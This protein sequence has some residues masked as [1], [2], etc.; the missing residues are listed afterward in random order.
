[1]HPFSRLSLTCCDQWLTLCLQ[2]Y[3]KFMNGFVKNNR[4][5]AFIVPPGAHLKP[6]VPT[7]TE[8]QQQ[9]QQS[10]TTS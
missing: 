9:Q 3:D 6:A 1:M 8:Q 10:N 5:K 2:Q 4:K 7:A